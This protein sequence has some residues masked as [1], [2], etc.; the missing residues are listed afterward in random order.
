MPDVRLS[1]SE[2]KATISTFEDYVGGEPVLA[3]GNAF[4]GLANANSLRRLKDP[5]SNGGPCLCA[6]NVLTRMARS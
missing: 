1:S 5:F 6:L 4:P 3:A 2:L